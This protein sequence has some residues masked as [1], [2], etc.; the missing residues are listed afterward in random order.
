MMTISTTTLLLLIEPV[1]PRIVHE[2]LVVDSVWSLRVK[3][4][5]DVFCGAAAH[6]GSSMYP[7]RWHIV[8][9]LPS[10]RDRLTF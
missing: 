4:A 1:R 2:L 9:F 5:V 6:T 8:H 10:R 3:S 7:I